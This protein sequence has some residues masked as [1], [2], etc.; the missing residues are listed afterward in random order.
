MINLLCIGLLL[1]PFVLYVVFAIRDRVIE[2]RDRFIEERR[3]HLANLFNEVNRTN[4][5]LTRVYLQA[6]DGGGYP[7][8][9]FMVEYYGGVHPVDTI[10]LPVR[11]FLYASDNELKGILASELTHPGKYTIKDWREAVYEFV[12]NERRHPLRKHQPR[13]KRWLTTLRVRQSTYIN[14][15]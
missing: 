5:K 12:L 9:L 14:N 10:W 7:Y 6:S 4:K 3:D 11:H 1:L 8:D 15:S 2:R 13:W